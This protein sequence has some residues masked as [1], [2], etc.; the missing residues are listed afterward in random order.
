MVYFVSFQFRSHSSFYSFHFLVGI[1]L[2]TCFVCRYVVNFIVKSNKNY[3]QNN[4]QYR[5]I[6]T[7]TKRP[8]TN[9][10][11]NTENWNMPLQ[12]GILWIS[13]FMNI[14]FFS[15]VNIWN[16]IKT[17]LAFRSYII[18]L[19][20]WARIIK[21]FYLKLFLVYF[22]NKKHM[23]WLSLAFLIG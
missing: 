7:E 4:L 15:Y 14:F 16:A 23:Q 9:E 19:V 6:F 21:K 18:A 20:V 12:Y 13:K 2:H 1:D 5:E 22:I 10:N 17:V 8:V 11:I 3:S